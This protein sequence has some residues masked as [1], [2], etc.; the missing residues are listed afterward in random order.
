MDLATDWKQAHLV[1]QA[2]SVHMTALKPISKG[3]EIFNDYGQLPRSD[4]LRRYGYITNSYKEWDVIEINADLI[5]RVACQQCNWNETD[6]FQRVDS[7]VLNSEL[8]LTWFQSQLAQMWDVDDDGFSI[9][10][11]AARLAYHHDPGRCSRIVHCPIERFS[12]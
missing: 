6:K 12:Q 9:T 4:L 1:Q 2:N 5:V 7:T 10:R 3:E 11:D 8:Q